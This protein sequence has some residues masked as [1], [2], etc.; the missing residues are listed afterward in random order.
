MNNGSRPYLSVIVPAHDAEDILPDT[1][2]ALRDSEYPRS[3]WELLVVDDASTDRTAEV[4]DEYADRVLE[5]KGSP[6]GPACA[7]NRG[8][9]ASRGEC[10]AFI[11]AD[12]RVHPDTIAKLAATL[13]E[14]DRWS[15]VFGSYDADPAAGGLVSRFRNLL[16]HWVHQQSAG[17]AETFWAGCGAVRSEV[18]E[19]VGMYDEWHYSQPEIEDIELGRRMRLHGYRILLRPD[20]QVTHL[21]AWSIGDMLVTDFLRRGV[22]W[23]R[24]LIHEGASAPTGALNLQTTQKVCTVAAPAAVLSV[25]AGFLTATGWPFQVAGF[26]VLLVFVFNLR[27]YI[28]LMTTQELWFPVAALPLHLLHYVTGAAAGAAGWITH[29]LFGPPSSAASAIKGRQDHGSAQSPARSPEKSLWKN[30]SLPATAIGEAIVAAG[31]SRKSGE[32]TADRLQLAFLPLH[33]RALGVAS[34]TTVAL[35][36]LTVTI[37]ELL[38][39]PHPAVNLGLMAEYFYGYEVSIRGAVTGAGWGWFVGFVAGWFLAFSRNL[40]L[41]LSRVPGAVNSSGRDTGFLEHL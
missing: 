21:K 24:L 6:R 12:C 40:V 36:I 30:G 9:E 8:F 18:F 35:L 17:E 38:I 23:T 33:K 3:Q 16:H 2:S 27:F 22:A 32:R 4:A 28:R 13:R 15:A 1:L 7:R 11:D 31:S 34:G 37:A 5:L 20:V 14:H 41:A 25:L 19:A 29:R 10:V 26:L 39:G